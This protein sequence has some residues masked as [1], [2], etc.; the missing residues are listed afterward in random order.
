MTR[1]SFAGKL[2]YFFYYL[3]TVAKIQ[4]S[5]IVLTLENSNKSIHVYVDASHKRKNE[6][7]LPSYFVN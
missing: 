7:E 3:A 1:N 5:F 6:I 2:T 4:L